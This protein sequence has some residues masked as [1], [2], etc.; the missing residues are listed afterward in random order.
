MRSLTSITAGSP[1]RDIFDLA[2]NKSVGSTQ[3]AKE[4]N[5]R[6]VPAQFGKYWGTSTVGCILNNRTYAGDRYWNRRSRSRKLND[7]A[8]WVLKEGTHEPLIDRDLFFKRKEAARKR[9]FKTSGSPRRFVRYLLSRLI[10]CAHCGHNF[11]GVRQPKRNGANGATYDLFRYVCHGSLDKGRSVCRAKQIDRDWLE[12]RALECVR[13][14]ICAPGQLARLEGLVR[15]RI[16][17]RRRMFAGSPRVVNQRIAA[18]DTKIRHYFEAIGEG[19]SPAVCKAKI[20]E[21]EAEKAKLEEEGS[22]LRRDGYYTRAIEKNLASL[23]KFAAAFDLRFGELPFE[24]QRE[25]VLHFIERIRVVDYKVIEIALWVPFDNNGVEKLTE[26][27]TMTGAQV[28]AGGVNDD[29]QSRTYW[30]A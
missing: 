11:V 24:V 20:S 15:E 30:W 5:R 6:G 17:A 7:P 16:E 22:I 29:S 1:V 27:V 4:L 10:L 21:L 28:G 12:A 3:I 2:A 14:E 8:R 25:V 9:G 18:V 23:R 26:A 19:L 13:N